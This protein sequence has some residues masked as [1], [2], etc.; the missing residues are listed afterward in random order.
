MPIRTPH[1]LS[2]KTVKLKSQDPRLDGR[3]YEVEDYWQ[4]VSGGSWADAVGNPAA[5]QYAM[6]AAYLPLDNEVL[7]GKVGPFGHLVHVSEIG[8]VVHP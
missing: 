1:A 2:G 7:Y 6:R 8:D 4:N 3:E 5:L